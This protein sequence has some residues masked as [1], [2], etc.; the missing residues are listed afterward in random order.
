VIEQSDKKGEHEELVEDILTIIAGFSSRIYGK[1]GGR[2]H[3][4][5]SDVGN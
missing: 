2:K 4:K 3:N 5:V 1:R